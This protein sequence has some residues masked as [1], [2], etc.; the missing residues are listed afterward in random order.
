[1]EPSKETNKLELNKKHIPVVKVVKQCK[2]IPEGC[3]EIP[4]RV[5][6]ILH[7]MTKDHHIMRI[8][9]YLDK[10]FIARAMLTPENVNP[11]VSIHLHAEKGRISVVSLC[12]LHGAW[13]SEVEL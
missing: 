11:A 2:L 3:T 5:G 1:M 7:P 6:E 12:N 10:K 8:D 9:V 13:L 4:V